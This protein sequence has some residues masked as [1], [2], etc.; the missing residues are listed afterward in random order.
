M[1]TDESKIDVEYILSR[2]QSPEPK[3]RTRMLQ[4]LEAEPIA[5]P[6]LLATAEALL[7]DD[8]VCL[9]GIPYVF[10]EVRYVAAGAVAAL[11]G[12]LN[13]TEPVRILDVLVPLSADKLGLLARE[14]G[15]TDRKGGIEGQIDDLVRLRT[16]GVAPRRN[17]LRTP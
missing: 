7:T 6:R 9:L 5:D 16:M 17:V 12:A 11:R 14:A 15:L 4:A 1:S 3:K 13:Q 8:T 2:L 10:G